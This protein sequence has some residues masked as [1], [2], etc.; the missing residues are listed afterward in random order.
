MALSESEIIELIQIRR[1]LHRRPELGFQEEATGR[2][3][4]SYLRELGCEVQTGI[5]GTGVVGLLRGKH[6]ERVVL[7]RADMDALPIQEAVPSDYQSERPGVMHA[8]G[9]DGHMAMAL[10]AA[11][12]LNAEKSTLN[13]SV[14]FV[15][16]PAEELLSGA[17]RMV[18]D[19]VLN[20]PAVQAAFGVHLWNN[21]DVGQVGVV[22]GPMMASVDRFELLIT[23]RGGHGAMP[24]QTIDPIVVAGHVVTALQTIVS[25]SV[26]PLEPA[27]VTIGTIHAGTAFNVIAD[28]ALM[29]GTVRVFDRISYES[30]PH[31]LEQI[32]A[33]VCH[34]FGAEYELRYDRFCEPMVNDAAM[35]MLA[36]Q[37]AS[38]IVGTGNVVGTN[39]A[40][41][42][43]GED[44]S[45]FLKHVPGCY[46]FVGS[47]NRARQLDQPHHSARFDFDEAALPIG[48]EILEGLA[49]SYLAEAV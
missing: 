18:D 40:R 16:Q 12:R 28:T 48:V 36:S 19:G 22:A 17:Q 44:M 11:Q 13:G 23:G 39:E 3:I 29:S 8:C 27:V 21:L 2:F 38:Q 10:M 33:G 14:K 26:N 5:G 49:K 24:H 30:V 34:A 35:A 6:S 15:F 43:C 7:L 4:A 9:H 37:V 31:Q 32:V 41:T 46:L 25:R 42:T 47:R 20:D 1:H 45:V